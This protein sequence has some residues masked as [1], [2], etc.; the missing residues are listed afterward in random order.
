MYKLKQSMDRDLQLFIRIASRLCPV[1]IAMT[2]RCRDLHPVDFVAWLLDYLDHHP[3]DRSWLCQ[4]YKWLT[5]RSAD[6]IPGMI[7]Q[8]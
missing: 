7:I 2:E 5:L 4:Q 6:M 3:R 1:H 8:L